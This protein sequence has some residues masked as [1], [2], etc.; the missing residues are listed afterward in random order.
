M[1]ILIIE[2]NSL[3]AM[4]LEMMIKKM[5]FEK[6]QKALNGSSA[7]KLLKEYR[8]DVML[9]DINLDTNISGIDLVKNI[10]KQHKPVVI[11]ISGN[12]DDHYKQ[13]AAETN[14]LDFLIKPID[15]KELEA[16]LTKI[17]T[18]SPET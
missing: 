16:L 8:P 5:G 12:S 11:Y 15:F 7:E 13:M 14:Y 10:P 18:S 17:S 4:I 9:V 6:V 2:D 3:Q 1:K